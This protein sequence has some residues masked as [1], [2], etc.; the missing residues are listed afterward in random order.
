[1]DFVNLPYTARMSALSDLTRA[2]QQAPSPHKAL[3]I[4]CTYLR[5]AHPTRAHILLSTSGLGKG[6][7]RVWRMMGDDGSEHL[8]LE[9]PW[10]GIGNRICRGGVI[11]D[12][13]AEKTPHWIRNVDWTTDPHFTAVLGQYESLIA[14]PLLNDGFPL[15]WSIMLSRDGD[16]FRFMIL[17]NPQHAEH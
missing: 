7:Y 1:M 17:K 5:D 11:A 12:V 16:H 2:L 15:T 6:E 10:K 4:Y 3:L 14:V 9:D 8:P 13:I